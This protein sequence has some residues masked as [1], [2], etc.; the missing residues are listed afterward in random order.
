MSLFSKGDILEASGKEAI[1]VVQ[2]RGLNAY[3]GYE[4]DGDDFSIMLFARNAGELKDRLKVLGYSE[5]T[6]REFLREVVSYDTAPSESTSAQLDEYRTGKAQNAQDLIDAYTTERELSDDSA[7]KLLE[8]LEYDSGFA[9]Y[10]NLKEVDDDA[11]VTLDISEFAY[12]GWYDDS[13]LEINQAAENIQRS[14]T[15]PIILTEGVFDRRVLKESLE[16]LYPH[17]TNY[18]KFLDTD[19]KTEGGAGALVKTL[20][21]F[22]AA[23]ISNRIIAIFDNDTAA[24]DAISGLRT[25]VLPANYRVIHY[26]DI[27]LG[28]S[29]PTLG[30]QGAVE[31]DINKLAGAIELYLGQ[32]TLVDDVGNYRPVQW[33]GYVSKL[34]KY[35]GEL[36]DK[37][38]IQDNFLE[39]LKIAK[40]DPGAIAGQDWTG[41]KLI[42]DT[43]LN[44]LSIL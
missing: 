22:A 41:M 32:D 24:Y 25:V 43:I 13:M 44:D 27:E 7:N 14:S 30:P 10:Y 23:G 20:K 3:E 8:Y 35:Q 15:S 33:T 34:A 36:L 39:K 18:I 6:F 31:M 19:Y 12:E 40:K 4:D 37:S 29:Y 11:N 38:K 17:L 28:N 1:E 42:I 9:L 26:P 16:L 21:S 5:E 2:A